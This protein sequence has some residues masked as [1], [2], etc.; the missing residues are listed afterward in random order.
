MLLNAKGISRN[1]YITDKTCFAINDRLK[2][3]R[4]ASHNKLYL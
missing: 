3:F 1:D 4:R 2:N